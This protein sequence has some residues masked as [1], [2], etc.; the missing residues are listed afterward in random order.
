MREMQ[1]DQLTCEVFV[2]PLPELFPEGSGSADIMA[3]AFATKHLWDH[4]YYRLKLYFYVTMTFL[5]TLFGVSG[6]EHL[7]GISL[8][9]FLFTP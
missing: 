6:I 1:M 2:L 5:L 8:W 9:Q 7:F 3:Q 4:R